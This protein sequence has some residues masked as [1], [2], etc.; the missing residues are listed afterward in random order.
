MFVAFA[1]ACTPDKPAEQPAQ[2]PK[3]APAP[4]P[5]TT[6]PTDTLRTYTW[7]STMCLYTGRYSTRRY[8]EEQ[9]NNA[10]Q[11]VYGSAGL[12]TDA[13][14]FQPENISKLSLDSLTVEYTKKKALYR[15]MQL[16]PQSIWQ[17]LQ[18]SAL[19]ELEDE[20]QAKKLTIQA[21][22][23]PEILLTAPYPEACKQ[24]IRGLITHNDSLML[25]DWQRLAEMQRKQNG[26]P[27]GYM[28]RFNAEYQRE[29]RLLY[30]KVDLLTF[31]WWN[32]INNSIHR[33]EITEKETQQFMQL[34]TSVKEDCEEVD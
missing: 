12:E 19:Q 11:F 1:A 2:A 33:V 20:Y 30:A 16:P 26:S 23:H 3:P 8:T 13:T 22:T 25:A 4:I 31:T 9:L 21:H 24:G 34:F 5:A 28:K 18:K 17:K 6:T 27:E 32:C 7:Q 29:D 10:R 15:G 14:V